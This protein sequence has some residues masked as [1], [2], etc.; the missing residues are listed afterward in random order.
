MPRHYD[1]SDWP[2]TPSPDEPTYESSNPRYPAPSI[3][4]N[5]FRL[6]RQVLRGRIQGHQPGRDRSGERPRLSLILGNG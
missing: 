6:K 1:E 3:L 5:R 4:L 2:Y